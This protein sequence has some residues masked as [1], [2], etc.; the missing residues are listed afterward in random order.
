MG[1]RNKI[2]IVV[3]CILLVG[4]IYF[5]VDPMKHSVLPKCIVYTLTGYK[6]PGC[7]S[8][9]MLHA[10]MHGD[11]IGAFKANAFLFCMLPFLAGY[12]YLEIYHDKHERFYDFFTT[13][14]VVGAILVLVAIWTVVR[15][16]WGM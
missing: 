3:L 13:G 9:R 14:K 1:R 8:Q 5:F 11:F 2:L 6:C 7:G 16:L 12:C 10:I 4:T 15:N